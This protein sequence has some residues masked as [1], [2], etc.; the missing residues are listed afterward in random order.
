M[1]YYTDWNYYELS[2]KLDIR[3]ISLYYEKRLSSENV[4]YITFP[5]TLPMNKLARNLLYNISEWFRLQQFQERTFNN[6][7]NFVLFSLEK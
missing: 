1:F 2:T 3:E 6:P 7:L 4:K 5:K